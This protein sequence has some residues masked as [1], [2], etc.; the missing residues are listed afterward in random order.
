MCVCV[1][2]MDLDVFVYVHVVMDP[3]QA[4][5][6]EHRP[7]H[8]GKINKCVFVSKPAPNAELPVHKCNC[9]AETKVVSTKRETQIASTKLL[10]ENGGKRRLR[11]PIKSGGEKADEHEKPVA[12]LCGENCHNRMLFISCSDDTCSAPDPSMCSNRA[13]KRRE[14]KYVTA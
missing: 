3:K 14:V 10:K 6:V 9:F 13:I 12:L 4:R 1:Y 2:R 8:Y 11:T 5:K 7:P